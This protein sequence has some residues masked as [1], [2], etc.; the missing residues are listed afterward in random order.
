MKDLNYYLHLPYT[1]T[2]RPDSDDGVVARVEELPGC[3]TDGAT[4]SEAVEKLDDLKR[5]WIEDAIEAGHSVPEP[6]PEEELPSGKWV[7]RVPRSLHRRLSMAAKKEGVSL[8]TLVSTV[9]SEAMGVRAERKASVQSNAV[10]AVEIEVQDTLNLWHD[11]F[12]NWGEAT[13][14]T[15]VTNHPTSTGHEV[16]GLADRLHLLGAGFPNKYKK[17]LKVFYEE[18]K[19]QGFGKA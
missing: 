9:L 8:N 10:S 3:S 11:A 2:L 17:P 6:S 4:V 13:S 18:E 15:I 12:T 7:Q 1:I 19:S 5:A 16:L 14:C